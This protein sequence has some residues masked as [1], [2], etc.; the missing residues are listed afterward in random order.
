MCVQVDGPKSASED[1]KHYMYAK[2]RADQ[3]L[4]ETDLNYTI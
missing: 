3:H 1:M 2:Y 4:Q